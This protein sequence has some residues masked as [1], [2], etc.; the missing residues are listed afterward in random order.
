M[1]LQRSLDIHGAADSIEY[2]DSGRLQGS[3]CLRPHKSGQKRIHPFLCNPLRCSNTGT[4]LGIHCRVHDRFV[5]HG[6]RV[7]DDKKRR[8]AESIIDPC[9]EP[10]S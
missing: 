10:L 2:Q 5:M 3:E 9:V 8:S 7:N 4:L 6:F 1:V